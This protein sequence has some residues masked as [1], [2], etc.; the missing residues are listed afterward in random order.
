MTA[1][2]LIYSYIMMPIDPDAKAPILSV[3]HAGL[4]AC[5]AGRGCWST[6]HGLQLLL[7]GV[8]GE[9]ALFLSLGTALQSQLLCVLPLQ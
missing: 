4:P 9:V 7:S 2:C 8:M 1:S 6:P 5:S 3:R